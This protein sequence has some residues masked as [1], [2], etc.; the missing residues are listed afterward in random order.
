MGLIRQA[1]NVV[2]AGSLLAVTVPAVA[3]QN[4]FAADLVVQMQQMQE[5]LRQLRGLVDQQGFELENIKR[6]QRDQYLD[7]D[8]RLEVLTSPASIPAPALVPDASSAG[9][10]AAADGDSQI[11]AVTADLDTGAVADTPAAITVPVVPVGSN[12][13]HEKASYDIAFDKLKGFEY[14]DAA[15]GFEAFLTAYPDSDFADN[16]QYWLGESYYATRNYE[17]AMDAF[18]HLLQRY[19]DSPKVPDAWLKIGYTHYELQQWDQARTSLM[20]VKKQY[21]DSTLARL[22]E[23]RLRTMRLDGH[24]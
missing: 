14:A 8:Q 12:P 2:T 18:Q 24:F 20:H 10:G 11:P 13:E 19:S 15:E 16:A 21:P 3:Q 6:R 23:N 22:A 7:L 1:L 5:E 9:T 17:F 4:D